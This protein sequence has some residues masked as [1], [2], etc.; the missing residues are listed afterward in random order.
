MALL[1][2]AL[3]ILLNG[4]WSLLE[5]WRLGVNLHNFDSIAVTWG[6]ILTN[7]SKLQGWKNIFNFRFSIKERL[8][9]KISAVLRFHGA[10][11]PIKDVFATIPSFLPTYKREVGRNQRH[12]FAVSPVRSGTRNWGCTSG[13][14]SSSS[15]LYRRSC[16][17]HFLRGKYFA[18]CIG[19]SLCPTTDFRVRAGGVR[20]NQ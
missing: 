13:I 6:I 20:G 2:E 1:V 4:L 8:P 19:N 12:H 5:V 14:S 18:R 10:V 15:W 7:F 3:N 17:V 9:R 11:Q 16:A